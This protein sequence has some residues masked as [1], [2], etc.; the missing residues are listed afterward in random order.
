LGCVENDTWND[1][2]VLFCLLIRRRDSTVLSLMY[3]GNKNS[4][5]LDAGATPHACID[6]AGAGSGRE[7]SLGASMVSISSLEQMHT[8]N[9][10]F[11][12]TR[13]FD[14]RICAIVLVVTRVRAPLTIYIHSRSTSDGTTRNTQ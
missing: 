9:G 5:Q 1:R 10:R 6:G 2:S 3:Q 11:D 13:F 4:L 7:C 12:E 14:P 8:S